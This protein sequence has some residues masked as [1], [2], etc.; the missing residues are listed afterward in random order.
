MDLKKRFQSIFDEHRENYDYMEIRLE[1]TE[2]QIIQLKNS[3]L[4]NLTSDLEAG[5]NV[6]V[7]KDGGWSFVVFNDLNDLEEMAEKAVNAAQMVGKSESTLAPI[8]PVEDEVLFEPENDPRQVGLTKK[9]ETLRNYCQIIDN[10][11]EPIIMSRI[12]FGETFT[13]LTFANSEGTHIVQ[14][15]YDMKGGLIAYASRDGSTESDVMGFG[16]IESVEP[17]FGREEEVKQICTNLVELMDAPRIKGGQYT[18]VLD[19]EMTGLFTHEAFGHLSEADSVSEN[20]SLR[21]TMKL[22]RTFGSEELS[23][24]DGAMLGRRGSSK[25]DDEGVRTEKTYLIKNGKL[26]GRLH[27]RETAGK[28]DAEPTGNARAISY[29][30]PPIPRMRTTAI[31]GGN[32][33]FEEMI[34][35]IDDGIYMVK[36]KGGKTSG[37]NFS[38]TS[39]Y[40]YRIKDGKLDGMVK[41]VTLTG[42][43]FQTLED[44]DMVADDFEAPNYPWACGKGQQSGLPCSQGGPHIRVR[45]VTIGGDE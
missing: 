8:E 4:E 5:G 11:G 31:E 23:I 18:V 2:N 1:R 41:G 15:K 33:T 13:T 25:Y 28:M 32:H 6:R 17:I 20:D 39:N 30:Y 3:D 35:D 37:E 42:N 19:P 29:K 16:S 9:I 26:V 12:F 27:T 36:A 34:A 40:G 7:L 38:F 43:V 45:N 14:E 10:Y 24:Y 21:E 44:I 22:G